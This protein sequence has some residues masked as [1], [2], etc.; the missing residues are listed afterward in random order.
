MSS[1][2][3]Y[4]LDPA[5]LVDYILPA[6]L[7]KLPTVLVRSG[8]SAAAPGGGGPLTAHDLAGPYHTGVLADSQ[9]PQFLKIDGSRPLTGNLAVANGVTVDGVDLSGHVQDPDAHHPQVH[10]IVTGNH[11]LPVGTAAWNLIGATPLNTLG[12]LLPLSDVTGATKEALLKSNSL[13]ELAAVRFIATGS[14]RAPTIDTTTGDLQLAPASGVTTAASLHAST[15]LRSP[16]IDTASGNLALSPSTGITTLADLRAS[17][18]LRSPLIDT[19]SGGLAVAPV[20]GIVTITGTT[21]TLT[22]GTGLSLRLSPVD[23]LILSPGGNQV[24]LAN[25][26]GFQSA[27]FVSG[28]AGNG[29]RLDQGISRTSKTSLELDDLVVRGRM[30]VYELLIRQIRA[31]NGAIFVTSTAKVKRVSTIAGGYRLYT[32]TSEE[33]PTA[34]TDMAHGFLTDDLLRAQRTRWNGTQLEVIYQCDLRVTGVDD[35][36]AFSVVQVAGGAPEPGMEFVRIGSQSNLD[37]RGS[38]YLTA[39]DTNAPFLDVVDGIASHT[40]WNTAGKVRV[41][42]GKLTG[43]TALPN[44]YGIIAGV[45]LSTADQYIKASNVEILLRNVPLKFYQGE[46]QKVHIGAWNDVWFGPSSADKRLYWDGSVAGV[47]GTVIASAG[48]IANWN[49]G[50]ID[51]NTISSTN[52]R[53]YAGDGYQARIELGDGT[54][55]VTAGIRAGGP[56]PTAIDTAFWAGAAHTNTLSAKYRVTMGGSLYASD[57]TLAG[58]L[59]AGGGKVIVGDHGVCIQAE[60]IVDPSI[61]SILWAETLPSTNPVAKVYGYISSFNEVSAVAFNKSTTRGARGRFGSVVDGNFVA[62]I[63]TTSNFAGGVWVH[64]V[65]LYGGLS[66]WADTSFYGSV[67]ASGGITSYSGIKNSNGAYFCNAT[68]AFLNTDGSN[69]QSLIASSFGNVSGYFTSDSAF[70][71]KNGNNSAHQTIYAGQIYTFGGLW[72]YSPGISLEGSI[73]SASTVGFLNGNQAQGIAIGSALV[74]SDYSHTSRVPTS[75]IYSLGGVAI[76]TPGAISSGY[77]LD[78]NGSIRARGSLALNA[79]MNLS[80]IS[81]PA[82]STVTGELWMGQDNKLYF[83]KPNGTALLVAG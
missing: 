33:A 39:D 38:L 51:A 64:G 53:L 13:G 76:G 9:G 28:F 77:M 44:E 66:V 40:D 23:Y 68:H 50:I 14:L 24:Q 7:P 11:T 55:A 57:S 69:Y 80:P 72:V 82:T 75:G 25:G 35:L 52:I 78:V 79:H 71:F 17:T 48:R 19:A 26:K 27:E 32:T 31:T 21:P 47:V 83:K 56:T 36:Y 15:R 41:R 1:R 61:T 22:T 29:F 5:T 67:S 70:Q 63:R 30:S 49:I 65:D 74:S 58:S 8:N 60:T 45:G 10:G 59:T 3:L 6:L 2:D 4:R 42:I 81:E 20:N 46:T 37:R 16:L 73:Y 54:P 34:T 18:R 62:G 12:L 43:I